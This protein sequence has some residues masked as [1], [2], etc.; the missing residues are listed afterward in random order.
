MNGQNKSTNRLGRVG[1]FMVRCGLPAYCK[2]G[3]F[4]DN[5]M[6]FS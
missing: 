6:I 5:L 2:A 3:Y 4:L 1:F